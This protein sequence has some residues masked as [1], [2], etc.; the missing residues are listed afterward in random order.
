MSQVAAV[1]EQS[2]LPHICQA[3]DHDQAWGGGVAQECP[4]LD[5]GDEGQGHP[6]EQAGDGVGKVGAGGQAAHH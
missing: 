3:Q 4:W 5:A 6:L 2:H 1:P